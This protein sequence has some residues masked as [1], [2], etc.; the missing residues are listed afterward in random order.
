MINKNNESYALKKPLSFFWEPTEFCNLSCKHCYTSSSPTKKIQLEYNQA[1]DIID[2]MY[3]EGIY[4]VGIG[5]GEP[6]LIPYLVDLIKYITKKNMNVSISTNA[7]MMDIEYAKRLKNAGLKIMQISVDGLKENHEFLR[8]IGTYDRVLEKI[9]IVKEIG[10]GLRVGSVINSKNYK[11]ID[12]FIDTMKNNGVEVINF[13]RYMPINKTGDYLALSSEQLK[14]VSLNLVNH[15]YNNV[16]ETDEINKKFYITFEPISFF[17]F[18]YDEHFLKFTK[19]TAGQAKFNLASNGDV[20]VCNYIEKKVGNI[21]ESKTIELWNKI[22]SEVESIL[23][24]PKE[25]IT[26]R[27][28]KQCKGGC[29]GFSYAIGKNFST[30]D[31]GCFKELL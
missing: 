9:K 30:K 1:K 19:C 5:G 11:Q 13:F 25:C 31:L 20:S 3:D 4:S 26:C 12:Y 14:V 24:I 2:K 27:Y 15:Y 17:S 21:K 8:G 16:Y 6:L 29:K 23:S 28:S 10:I 18:L 7:L 22:R